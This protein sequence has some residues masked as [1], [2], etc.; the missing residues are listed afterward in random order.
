MFLTLAG[1][2]T[3]P[4]RIHWL[5]VCSCAEVLILVDKCLLLLPVSQLISTAAFAKDSSGGGDWAIATMLVHSN[6]LNELR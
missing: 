3:N 1:W 2:F 4:T 6:E 5:K